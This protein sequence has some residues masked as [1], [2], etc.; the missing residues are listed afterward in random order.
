[1]DQIA[2]G[3][4]GRNYH[5]TNPHNIPRIFMKE[6]SQVSRSSMV[7]EPFRPS[8]AKRAQVLDGIPWD[9][10]PY[11]LGYVST[12]AKDQAE[13]LMV[14]EYGEPIL[15]RWR[16]GLGKVAVFTSD[17]K[18]RWAVQWVRWP[19]YSKFW[20]QLI[21][22][23]M[24]TD[25]RMNL[26]MRTEV[27]QGEAQIV[28]DAVDQD[29][30]F[31]NDL[32]S[33]VMLRDPSGDKEPV[34]LDQTAA[35]RYEARVPL[36]AYGSYSLQAKHDK[37]GDTIGVSLGS[38]SYPYP[39]EYLFLEPNREMLRRAADIARGETNPEVATLFDPMGEEVKY[40]RELW[41]YFLMAALGFLLLD[42]A[43]RR[44]RL[45]GST[46]LEWEKFFG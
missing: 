2:E 17:L 33:T 14:S 11:L 38:I 12:R 26:A 28:V 24:R 10:A 44:I 25:D 37:D 42:L 22:D 1:L 20:A 31:I 40:R 8:I 19:G 7:E 39:R 36:S 21:R 18:N 46:D 32:E 3:G 5:T 45:W 29:D 41:P 23:T 9:R 34:E 35:G 16:H 6:T 15:A 13:V 4:G 30:Q 27:V 43:F